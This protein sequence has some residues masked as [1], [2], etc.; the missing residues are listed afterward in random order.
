MIRIPQR[1]AT[2]IEPDLMYISGDLNQPLEAN[3]GKI[4]KEIHYFWVGICS[5]SAHYSDQEDPSSQ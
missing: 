4:S 5:V 2:I 3:A 1:V